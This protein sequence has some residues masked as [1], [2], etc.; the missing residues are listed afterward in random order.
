M[1][2]NPGSLVWAFLDGST[3]HCEPTDAPGYLVTLLCGTED[4]S[5]SLVGPDGGA[6]VDGKGVLRLYLREGEVT[7][8]TPEL[9]YVLR[10]ESP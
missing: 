9:R 8:M 10:L 4:G 3:L 7:A 2:P 5:Y 6:Q 1:T